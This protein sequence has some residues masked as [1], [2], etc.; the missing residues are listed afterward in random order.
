MACHYQVFT[1]VVARHCNSVSFADGSPGQGAAQRL[2]EI[3]S[4]TSLKY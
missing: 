3:I 2:V 1:F 4:N